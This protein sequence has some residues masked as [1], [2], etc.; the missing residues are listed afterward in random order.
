[1]R[2]LQIKP[3]PRL[4]PR[5]ATFWRDFLTDTARS[6]RHPAEVCWFGDTQSLANL[7]ASYIVSGKKRACISLVRDYESGARMPEI[8]DLSL[9]IDG[10]RRPRAVIRTT[11]V[12][13]K[14]FIEVTRD[15]AWS[16]G[17]GPRSRAAWLRQ[18]RDFFRRQAKREGFT[19][20]DETPAVFER[21]EMIWPKR[22]AIA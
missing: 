7:L 5:Q 21:F 1:M 19:F 2:P 8:D 4:S 11:R 18:H 13:I 16:E 3:D 9:V 22:P 20:S 10:L 6:W 15:F 17:E 12:A 14:S